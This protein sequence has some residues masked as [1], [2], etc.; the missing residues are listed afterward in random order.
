MVFISSIH[1]QGTPML[2]SD[3]IRDFDALLPGSS[4]LAGASRRT[5]LKAG[6]LGLAGL[7]LGLTQSFFPCHRS[8]FVGSSMRWTECSRETSPSFP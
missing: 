3:Q 8:P 6:F 7:S 2:T 4:T 5:A 1:C